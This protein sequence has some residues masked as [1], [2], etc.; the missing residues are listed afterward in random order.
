MTLKSGL[1]DW[2]KTFVIGINSSKG[3]NIVVVKN[4]RRSTPRIR[5]GKV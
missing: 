4:H 5:D 1:N 2:R 3:M